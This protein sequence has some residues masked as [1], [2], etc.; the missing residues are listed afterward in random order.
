MFRSI[1][2]WVCASIV[3]FL[4]GSAAAADAPNQ[5]T[6]DEKK[7]GWKLLFDGKSLDGW[8]NF[9]REGVR[10]GWKVEDGALVC[11]NPKNAGDIVTKDTFDW[12]ELSIEFKMTEGGNSGIIFHVTDVG[13]TVWQ[14]GPEIQLQDNKKG[15]DPQKCGWLYQLYKPENDPRTSQP[16]DATKPVGEWNHLKVVIAKAPAKSEIAL[17]G[18]KYFDFEF[19]SEDFKARIA[20]SKFAKMKDFAKSGSGAISLQGDHGAVSFRNIKIKPLA[21]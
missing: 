17:N 8:H 2:P 12:F 18:T 20:K 16:L 21:K 19:G 15:T 14:T 7:A 5:L 9:K 1:R 4:A 11:A 6:D 13:S 10:P 3:L